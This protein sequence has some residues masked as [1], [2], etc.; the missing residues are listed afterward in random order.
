MREDLSKESFRSMHPES[1]NDAGS[2]KVKLQL[3]LL[4][5]EDIKAAATS[6]LS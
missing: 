2:T 4:P 3:A 1:F 6:L 5:E